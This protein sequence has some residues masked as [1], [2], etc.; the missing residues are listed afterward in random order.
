MDVIVNGDTQTAPDGTTVSQLLE[1][2]QVRPER[3]VVEV[4]LNILKRAQH[5]DTVLQ[6]GDTIEIVQFV[7]G[8]A[9][10]L[11]AIS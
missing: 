2:L 3:V 6:P 1:R 7:G 5:V 11:S 10:K 8:G 4:N 9:V